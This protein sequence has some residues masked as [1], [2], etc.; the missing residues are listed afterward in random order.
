MRDQPDGINLLATAEQIIRQ[1]VLP[2]M[3]KQ[4][5]TQMLMCLRA[6]AIAQRQLRYGDAPQQAELASVLRFVPVPEAGELTQSLTEANRALSQQIRQGLGDP[7][8]AQRAE[9]I[10]HLRETTRQRVAESNPKYL[11]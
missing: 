8:H 11:A 7:G 1:Q 3:P 5:H 4:H 9:L 6:M 10:E 2:D